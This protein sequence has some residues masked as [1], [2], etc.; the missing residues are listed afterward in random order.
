[1][2]CFAMFFVLIFSLIVFVSGQENADGSYKTYFT[3][4]INEHADAKKTLAEEQILENLKTG[5]KEKEDMKKNETYLIE[6]KIMISNSV[7]ANS[8]LNLTI[9]KYGNSSQIGVYL[10]NGEFAEVK[11]LPD[12]ASAI[13]FKNVN[14]D[15]AGFESQI[16]LKEDKNKLVYSINAKKMVRIFWIFKKELD[17][18]ADVDA[19]SGEVINI[20][21]PW[22]IALGN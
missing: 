13:A 18:K 3:N 14:K 1:M 9:R 12:Q 2:L 20:Q 10:S 15:L 5:A 6:R 17:V 22:W 7:K 21:K 11:Y 16:E 19:E 4:A 8:K